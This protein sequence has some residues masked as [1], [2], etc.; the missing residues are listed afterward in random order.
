MIFILD[1]PLSNLL[2]VF[3]TIIGS[4]AAQQGHDYGSKLL[5]IVFIEEGAMRIHKTLLIPVSTDGK[6]RN[7]FI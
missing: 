4:I 1:I 3:L 6:I 2:N 7:I 5:M